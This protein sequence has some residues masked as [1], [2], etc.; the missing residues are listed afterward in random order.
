MLEAQAALTLIVIPRLIPTKLDDARLS[1]VG[2]SP[3]GPNFFWNLRKISKSFPQKL[4]ESVL[5]E[6]FQQNKLNEGF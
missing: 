3:R 1:T 6:E 5:V 2:T 4:L